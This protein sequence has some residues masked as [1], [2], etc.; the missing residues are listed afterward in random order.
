MERVKSKFGSRFRLIACAFIISAA[1]AYILSAYISVITEAEDDLT[2]IPPSVSGAPD[3]LSED[4][5]SDK[6]RSAVMENM[7]MTRESA[8]AA[9]P[10]RPDVSAAYSAV[11]D[12]QTDRLLY[13]KASDV[14]TPMASTTKI[15]TF[16]VAYDECSDI[17]ETVTVSRAAA[18]TPGSSMHLAEGETITLHD[19]LFGLLMNSGNDAA[20]AIAE[21]IGGSIED[22]CELMND[23]AAEIGACDT[24][25]KTPHGLDTEGHFT[26][27]YDLALIAAEAYRYPLFR[28]ITGT[29]TVTLG[30][31][32]LKNTNPLLGKYEGVAGGKTGYTD[33]AGRCLVFFIDTPDVK[34]VAVLLGCPSSS[35]RVSDGVKLL[36]YTTDNF[37]TYTLLK[38]GYTVESFAVSKG[39]N[40]SVDAV[41]DSDLC[42]TLTENEASDM[43][44]RYDRASPFVSSEGF[45]LVPAP[46]LYSDILGT[47]C[48]SFGS[49]YSVSISACAD[50]SV[51]RKTY[52][53]HLSDMLKMLPYVIM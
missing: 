11:L 6:I 13:D 47:V 35:E 5:V 43:S 28:E 30:G 20:V 24:C 26:T 42:A 49:T 46:V 9:L 27:A 3:I 2:G 23:R 1:A 44:V 39:R 32:F 25:F 50:M 37:R 52:S 45:P 18:G 38:R 34:A 33:D 19:L 10:V 12:I 15:M 29:G 51:L 7:G 36:D 40:L 16:I 14:R 22:F 21:H 31:H 4:D 17:N 53:D 48:I 41:I 8:D